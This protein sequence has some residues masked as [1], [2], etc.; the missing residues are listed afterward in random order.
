MLVAQ[1]DPRVLSSHA[2][3]GSPSHW[4][5][6]P[7]RRCRPAGAGRFLAFLCLVATAPASSRRLVPTQWSGAR[8]RGG[9]GRR[10]E[11]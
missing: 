3:Q 1:K 9:R 6:P 2:R 8:S 7:K 5:T 11:E 4:W 10:A